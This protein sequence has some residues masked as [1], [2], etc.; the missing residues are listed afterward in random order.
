MQTRS[1]LIKTISTLIV[2]AVTLPAAFGQN[3]FAPALDFNVFLEKDAILSTNESEGPIAIGRDLT[4]AGSYVVAAHSAGT[5]SVGGNNIGLLVDGQVHY[6]S[7]NGLQVNQN[8]YVKIGT[9]GG[10][11]VWYYDQ[12]NAAS[13][14]RITPTPNYNS[15]PRIMLQANSNQLNVGVNNNPVIESGLIDFAAAFQLL[16]SSSQ[17]IAQ[18]THNANLTNANGNPIPNNNFPNQVKIDLSNGVNYLNISGSDLNSIQVFTYNQQPN[19]SRILVIN[20]DAPGTFNWN[21]W[22]QAGIGFQQSKYILYNF[23]NTT[24]LNIVGNSTISGSIMAPYADIVKT[25]NQS[26]IQGQIIGKSLHH[27]GGEMHYAIFSGNI[28]G[29]GATPTPP[30]SGVKPTADFKINND[31][32]CLDG[33]SF[34]FDNKTKALDCIDLNVTTHNTPQDAENK[35]NDLYFSAEGRSGNNALNG[36]FELDIHN[37]SPYNVLVDQQFVWQNGVDK[38]FSIVYDPTANGDDKFVFTI[39]DPNI[40]VGVRVLKLDPVAAGYPN[41]INGF[42]LYARIAENTTLLITDVEVNGIPVNTDFGEINPPKSKTVNH[43]FSGNALDNGINITGK[44]RLAWTGNIPQNSNMNFNFKMGNIDCIPAEVHQ[45]SAPISYEWDFGDNTT[46]TQMNP[47]KT[48][49]NAGTYDVRLIGENT[50]GKDTLIKQVTVIDPILT[51]PTQSTIADGSGYITKQALIADSANYSAVHWELV[52]SANNLFPNQYK[53]DFTF[54][55]SGFFQ[56]IAHLTDTNGCTSTANVNFSIASE[57]VSSGY[58]GAIESESLGDAVSKVYVNR[59]I[60]SEPTLFNKSDALIFKKW[61]LKS[62]TSTQ[63]LAQM[64]PTQMIPGDVA[65]ITSPTDILDYT[66]AHE[67]LSVDFSVQGKT[68]GVVLGVKT[69]D[70]VYNHTKASCDRL[71]GAEILLVKE[72]NV[73]GYD[74]LMQVMRQRNGEIEYAISFAIGKNN[75]DTEYTLQSGWFVNHYTA[76]NEVYNFQ[77][78][79]VLPEHT[80]KLTEDIFNNLNDF[81]PVSQSESPKIPLSYVSKISRARENLIL[82]LHSVAPENHIEITMEENFSETNGYSQRYN[83]MTSNY[84][85]TFTLNVKDGYEYD[86]LIKV[87]GDIQDAFYHA[88]GNWGLDFDKDYT[89]IEQYTVSNDFERIYED[90]ELPIHRNVT[91]RMHTDYDYITLYK[92]LLPGNLP[93]DYSEYGYVSFKATGSGLMDIGLVKSSITD[94]KKQYKATLNIRDFEQ[95]YYIPFSH[96]QSSGPKTPMSADDLTLLTFTFL[97]TEAGTNNLDLNIRDVKFTKYAPPGYED[98]LNTMTDEFYVY[99]NPSNGAFNCLLYSETKTEVNIVIRDI[100]G[101]VVHTEKANIIEGRNEFNF[102]LNVRYSTMLFMHIYNEE[103]DFGTSKL[104]VK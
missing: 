8:G 65:H 62:G 32:Q 51:T 64:F 79:T 41:D 97:A 89:V 36:T 29:S 82:K 2:L 11:T 50:Y 71:R 98:L 33:N 45:A 31:I 23:H 16:Q 93:A 87:N 100:T 102:D 101:V 20:V 80:I 63:N 53:V 68:Q 81:L 18:N 73:N 1:T 103:T 47:T 4:L 88:D 6:Q 86:G 96:F 12:N 91:L 27:S 9:G 84:E 3:P 95:T 17:N 55:V 66:I 34:V 75:N 13:P 104:I 58:D 78:W 72:V 7:G 70:R 61:T 10:S 43:I 90:D 24:Q 69:L 44:V 67:V 30:P 5:F 42:L 15:S 26:N 39:G 52:D 60:K 59:K 54:T 74:L 14:I 49:S 46:S 76:S 92:S 21:V 22:N 56:V 99:P 57:D 85:Q 38:P 77:V 37:V 28:P 94:W 48:Y 35:F 25:A 83:P 40:G 19:A